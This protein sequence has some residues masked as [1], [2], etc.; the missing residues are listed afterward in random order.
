MSDVWT[1][2]IQKGGDRFA[3]RKTDD[4]VAGTHAEQR[5]ADITTTVVDGSNSSEADE[6]TPMNIE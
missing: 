3:T 6:R 5:N 4:P 1:E 2:E